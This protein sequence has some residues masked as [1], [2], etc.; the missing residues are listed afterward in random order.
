MSAYFLNPKTEYESA[1]WLTS[2]FESDLWSIRFDHKTESEISWSVVLDDGSVLTE[3]KNR[4]L[5]LGLK[6]YLTASTR[7]HHGHLSETNSLGAQARKFYITCHIIDILLINSGRFKLSNYG[8]EGLTEGNLIEILETISSSATIEEKIYNWSARLR[9]YCLQLLEET[10]PEAISKALASKPELSVITDD[11]I[12]RNTLR[13]PTYK[14]PEVRAALLLNNLYHRQV[15]Y[16]NQPNTALISRKLYK[17]TFWGKHQSKPLHPILCYNKNL[18]MAIREYPAVPVK[19][20]A[21]GV[22]QDPTYKLYKRALYNLGVLHEIGIPA[23][24]V[25]ALVRADKFTPQLPSTGRF[26]SLPSAVV[27]TALRQAN[28]LHIEHGEELTNAF[29]RIAMECK[30]RDIQPTTLTSNEISAI[31]GDNLKKLGVNRLSLSTRAANQNTKTKTFKPSKSEYFKNLRANSGFLELIAIYIGGV[32]LTTGIL[33]ARRASELYSLQCEHCLDKSESYLIFKNAKSTRHLFGYRQGEARPIEPIASEMIKTLI[34]MQTS[35][36]DIGYI[37]STQTLFATPSLKGSAKLIDSS[38]HVFDRNLDLFCDYFETPTNSDGA[39][40]YLRQHQLR[41]FFAML[42]FYCGS[43]AKLDTLQWM[44]GH[45]DPTHVYRYITESTDGAVLAGTKAQFIAEQLHQ[46]NT[47]DYSDL[48]D[49]LKEKYGT[50]NFSLID[51]ND[52]EDQISDLMQEGWL[53]IE[54][55]FFSDHEGKKFKVVARL[56]RNKE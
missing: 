34:R 16:G 14:I 23:P 4:N 35:L 56:I 52:L 8:L 3:K 9:K 45:A 17:D 43:F 1:I 12:D 31:V 48:A 25:D 42:F 49:L 37:E 10:D 13:I 53:E 6:Y 11:Q 26:R 47:Q 30:S 28:E 41:R 2:D 38:R 40:Y 5:L 22:M 51:T 18:S 29:C 21:E 44:L 15:K 39:R 46:G 32:Q 19:H 20:G 27:F 55:E 36:K 50:D 54:P 33:M 24:P 7:D